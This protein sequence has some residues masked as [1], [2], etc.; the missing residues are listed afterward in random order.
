[1]VGGR[2]KNLFPERGHCR[3]DNHISIGLLRKVHMHTRNSCCFVHIWRWTHKCK[4]VSKLC[5]MHVEWKLLYRY[6][7]RLV[8]PL[9][10][11]RCKHS[12]SFCTKVIVYYFPDSVRTQRMAEV[13]SIG[14]SRAQCLPRLDPLRSR[15]ASSLVIPFAHHHVCASQLLNTKLP[16][17]Q[18]LKCFTFQI[19]ALNTEQN[20]S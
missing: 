17:N 9:Y 16:K 14:C 6:W 11:S 7:K 13:L 12:Y 4:L 3:Q 15:L 5:T 19:P 10:I 8:Y 20:E 2:K 1:M 18:A